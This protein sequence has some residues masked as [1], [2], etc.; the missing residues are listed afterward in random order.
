MPFIKISDSIRDTANKLIELVNSHLEY[1]Q[2]VAFDKLVTLLSKTISSAIIALTAFMVF[3]FFS[4]ALAHFIGELCDHISFGFLS[5]AALYAIGGWILW[6]NRIKWIIDPVISALT[7]S[8]EETTFDLGL[9]DKEEVETTENLG[10][11]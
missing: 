3:F 5:V 1:Y 4:W 9:D 6:S 7:E 11:E 8:I 2:I 10:D